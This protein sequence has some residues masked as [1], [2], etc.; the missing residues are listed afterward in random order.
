MTPLDAVCGGQSNVPAAMVATEVATSTRPS[1][2]GTE[3]SPYVFG[4]IQTS[5]SDTVSDRALVGT[6]NSS[7]ILKS[8]LPVRADGPT[9]NCVSVDGCGVAP[10][11]FES[12][13][14]A[15]ALRSTCTRN[16]FNEGSASVLP[17]S[18]L[19]LWGPVTSLA[20]VDPRSNQRG[21]TCV[22]EEK[23][24]RSNSAPAADPHPWGTA[25]NPPR[26]SASG[27]APPPT[28]RLNTSQCW[29]VY[30]KRTR[31]SAFFSLIIKVRGYLP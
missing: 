7:G 12:C 26:S 13:G 17:E 8:H 5:L 20:R 28:Y 16:L 9:L 18:L 19:G 11:S 30:A 4:S 29:V 10:H 22:K 3:G 2:V 27:A 6:G 14:V 23:R 15:P 31:L 1:C 21:E 24:H 25:V